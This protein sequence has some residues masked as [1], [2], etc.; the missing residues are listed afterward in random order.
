ML[1]AHK[2]VWQQI[3]K[4]AVNFDSRQHPGEHA[5]RGA[6]SRAG[7]SVEKHFN[8]LIDPVLNLRIGEELRRAL[9]G[10]EQ[11]QI[12]AQRLVANRL[13]LTAGLAA[14]LAIAAL[15]LF[16]FPTS[17]GGQGV[18]VRFPTNQVDDSTKDAA[19]TM[20]TVEGLGSRSVD[21]DG[22]IGRFNIRVLRESIIAAVSD[23]NVAVQAIADA[24]AETC[25]T[26]E[27]PSADPATTPACISPNGLQTVGISIYEEFDY[28]ELGRV[29]QG[30]R[31][32][33]RLAI[34]IRGTGF[35][36]GLVDLVIKSGGDLVRFDGLDFTT[37]RRSEFERLA[38]LDAID[39]AQS[40]ANAIAGHMGYRIARIVELKPAVDFAVNRNVVVSAQAD[41]GGGFAPTRVFAGQEVITSRVTM[42]FELRPPSAG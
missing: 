33:N 12:L 42:V 21:Y 35:A 13:L 40:T 15:A 24:V 4:I 9:S 22:A 25:T 10:E 34:A 29:S 2:R 38:L 30:F 11:M 31:Y 5:I 19:S 1:V 6:S 41:A 16:T 23:G 37:S 28:T 18:P 39:D 26:G 27:T 7:C 32:E 20:L 3:H 14:F 17:A 36:G 8:T